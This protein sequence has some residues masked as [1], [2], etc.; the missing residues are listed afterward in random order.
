MDQLKKNKITNI[1]L[2][3]DE[4]LITSIPKENINDP[5]IQHL[6][7]YDTLYIPDLSMYIVI[8]PYLRLFIKQLT[9]KYKIGIWT[10]AEKSY[11]HS[12]INI[13]FPH[14]LETEI[15]ELVLTREHVNHSQKI[16]GGYKNISYIE[17]VTYGKWK[18]A[19]T[20][21]IDDNINVIQTNQGSSIYI[22]PFI[23]LI[24]NFGS[25]YDTYLLNLLESLESLESLEYLL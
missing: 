1:L 18:K 22:P 11:A 20:C 6:K 21:I 7:S 24:G 12:I 14:F 17:L 3:L 10:N 25:V 13:L 16:F 2:D 8:R 23:F 4:T 5:Y 15:P 9:K 19:N